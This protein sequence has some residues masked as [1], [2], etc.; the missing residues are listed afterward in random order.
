[1]I[2]MIIII[3]MMMMI[4]MMRQS[5]QGKQEV[6]QVKPGSQAAR[7][8]GGHATDP[9]GDCLALASTLGCL[10]PGGAGSGQS[11]DGLWTVSRL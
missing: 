4:I 5:R 11:L 3:I 7:Q 6:R 1:M 10:R 2:I 9:G 8:P